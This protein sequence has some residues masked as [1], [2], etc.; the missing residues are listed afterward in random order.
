MFERYGMLVNVLI[1][2][3]FL[4]YFLPF[5]LWL[6]SAFFPG[7]DAIKLVEYQAWV[8]MF[9]YRDIITNDSDIPF[10]GKLSSC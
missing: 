2:R 3:L 1:L 5:L 8:G 7:F 9:P 4:F 10:T 6:N